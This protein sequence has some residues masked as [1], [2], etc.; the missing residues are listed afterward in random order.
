[1][2]NCLLSKAPFSVKLVM[3]MFYFELLVLSYGP[4]SWPYSS[5]IVTLK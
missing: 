3:L 1:M 5:M 4:R 2:A